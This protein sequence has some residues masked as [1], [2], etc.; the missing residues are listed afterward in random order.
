MGRERVS[1][2]VGFRPKAV[3]AD[4]RKFKEWL[5]FQRIFPR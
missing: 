1:A 4:M 5:V 3:F 2:I